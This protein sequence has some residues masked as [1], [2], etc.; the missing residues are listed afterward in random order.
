MKSRGGSRVTMEGICGLSRKS[1]KT[2]EVDM[3]EQK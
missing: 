1:S 3:E 2:E